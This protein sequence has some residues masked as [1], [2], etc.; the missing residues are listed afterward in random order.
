VQDNTIPR[1]SVMAWSNL[2]LNNNKVKWMLPPTHH[3]STNGFIQKMSQL[4]T[5]LSL[6]KT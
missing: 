5:L 6:R 3:K 1:H 4:D 2:S